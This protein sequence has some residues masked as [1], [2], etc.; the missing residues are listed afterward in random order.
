MP[1]PGQFLVSIMFSAHKPIRGIALPL[2][3]GVGLIMFGCSM[4]EASKFYQTKVSAPTTQ[5]VGTVSAVAGTVAGSTLPGTPLN[6][7]ANVVLV[8]AGSILALDRV[9]TGAFKTFTNPTPP[10]PPALP[11]LVNATVA[12]PAILTVESGVLK[13]G[14]KPPV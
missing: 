11:P 10:P 5:V 2:I 8:V 14:D 3:F 4:D 7:A 9:I 12:P 6:N 13:G 1:L